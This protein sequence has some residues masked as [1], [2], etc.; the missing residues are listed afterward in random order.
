[1]FIQYEKNH[2]KEN[3]VKQPG[4][5]APCVCIYMKGV[6]IASGRARLSSGAV[7]GTSAGL[8]SHRSGKTQ[9]QINAALLYIVER[10]DGTI[11]NISYFLSPYGL[12]GRGSIPSRGKTFLLSVQANIG[13]YPASHPMC[14]WGDV[15][16]SKEAGSLS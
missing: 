7:S 13:G 2:E 15:P 1:L 14:T 9:Q 5:E 11:H 3:Q 16:G 10:Q 6:Q 4:Q 8:P 12:D